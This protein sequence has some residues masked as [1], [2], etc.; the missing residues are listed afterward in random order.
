MIMRRAALHALVI[1][2][3]LVAGQSC[4]DLTET[5]RDALTPGNA[6]KTEQELLAGV[7]S[8]YAAL[9][10]TRWGY[11][12]LSEITTDEMIVP[13][14]GNDWYDNGRWLEIHRQSWSA[15]SGSA[16]DDMNGMWNDLF[17][18][19][20]RA[21]LMI[22]VITASGGGPTGKRTLA[23]LR[24]L[25]AWYYFLLQDMFGG[26]PLVTSTELKQHPRAPRAEIFAFIEKE[27]A[28]SR[29]ELPLKWEA[30]GYGRLTRG[31]ANAI[32]ASLY[33]NA[34]V[35]SRS[36]GVSA[37][38][39]NS[40]TVQAGGSTGC[41]AA[42][43]AADAVINS[44]QY[45]LASDWKQNFSTNNESSPENIFVIVHSSEQALGGNLPMRTLHYNQLATGWGGPWNGFATLAET[46]RAFEPTDRRR[47]MWLAGQAFSFQTGQPVD[48]RNGNKL[49]FSPDILDADKAGEGDGVRFNKFPPL[50]GAPTGDGHPN[51]FP[52]FRLAEMYLI[53][54]EAMNELG[55]TAAAL[56]LV[57]QV[58]ARA[59]TTPNPLPTMSQTALRD[60][61]LRERL[62]E[63][64]GEAKRRQDLVRHGKYLQRWSATMRNG[65][66][67]KTGEPHRILMPIPATQ[68]Q[69]NPQLQ[70]N[71][72][73]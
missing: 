27:I 64:A 29:A 15:G 44:G 28:E 1:A 11:Y 46:Y 50:P 18:G 32:L 5:P 62:L 54:A 63:F 33:L 51:D 12:N 48:D 7:A 67:D 66:V 57:N 49:V 38:G 17:S 21:N 4:T 69:S 41:Q 25:R 36:T 72:G 16:L 3:L 68:I 40:C 14:R 59:F 13:T 34:G 10:G 53:K 20:A 31:A 37:V 61:I 8:V 30:S 19:V 6:F 9:R 52:F 60:A 23:E 42:I 26:V 43:A 2:P 65:K 24:T 58:R 45:S 71:P 39:Y 56:A 70:Q 55:Q 35:F 22:E 47:E 73:Y